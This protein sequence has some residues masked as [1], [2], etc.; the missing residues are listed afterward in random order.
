LNPEDIAGQPTTP[1]GWMPFTYPFNFT[2]LPAASI[3]AGFSKDGL[4]I[5]MQIVGRKFDDLGVL[6]I[7]KAFE[8]VA[9]WQKVKPK[10]T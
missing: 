8:D 6:R 3:P 1:I 9:P 10:I 7:S 5:G 4:P 2:G